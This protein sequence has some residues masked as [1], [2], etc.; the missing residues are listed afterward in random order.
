MGDLLGNR[1]QAAA[2]AADR[3]LEHLTAPGT[4]ARDMRDRPLSLGLADAAHVWRSKK[5][6]WSTSM[7][8]DASLPHPRGGAGVRL[9]RG[10]GSPASAT[11]PC[12][13]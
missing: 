2:V 8:F 9:H 13:A 1:C 7:M 11:L 5:P 12:M 10:R 3:D 4:G 6:P